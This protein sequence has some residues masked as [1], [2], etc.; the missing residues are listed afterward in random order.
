MECSRILQNLQWQFAYSRIVLDENSKVWRVS[1]VEQYSC[2]LPMQACILVPTAWVS[3]LVTNSKMFAQQ[4]LTREFNCDLCIGGRAVEK[5]KSGQDILERFHRRQNENDLAQLK[6]SCSDC[7]ATKRPSDFSPRRAKR[8]VGASR[9]QPPSPRR[10][11]RSL[12]PMF[13][14][15]LRGLSSPPGRVVPHDSL[16]SPW[17]TLHHPLRG[18]AG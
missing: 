13:R 2:D 17:A 10:G 4:L 1:S 8:V 6:Q 11:R 5:G 14:R 15:P 12:P 9:T 16:R 3:F 18:F 7:Q